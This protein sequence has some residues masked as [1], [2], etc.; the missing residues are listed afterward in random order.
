[1]LLEDWDD[2]LPC[3]VKVMPKD[4]RRALLEL[5]A[6]QAAAQ[7]EAARVESPA[8]EA[9]LPGAVSCVGGGFLFHKAYIE[10]CHRSS[11]ASKPT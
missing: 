8:N 4:Y 5:R 2:A 9:P 3:F 1:M 11:V 6:E 7:T 10:D